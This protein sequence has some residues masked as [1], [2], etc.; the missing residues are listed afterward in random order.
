MSRILI[1]GVAGFIGRH[2]FERL[3]TYNS[4][5]WVGLDLKDKVTGLP[6]EIRLNHALY[7]CD[8]R[9]S[10]ATN[11][12]AEDMVTLKVD[13]V[14]HLAAMAA[15]RIAESQPEVTWATNV[16]GTYNLLNAMH[17]AKVRKLVFMS[18]AH[19]YGISPKYMPTDESHPLALLDLYT[20]SKVMGEQLCELFYQN[21]GIDYVALRLYNGYGPGQSPDYFMGTKIR[22]AAKGDFELRGG[23][24]TKDWVYIDDVVDAIWRA[25][26]TAYVGPLNIGTGEE[27]SLRD[28]ATQ[29]AQHFG[30]K[31]HEVV[32]G[33]GGPTRMCADN[34]RARRILDWDPEVKF[35]K[36]LRKTLESFR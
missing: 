32:D 36:G 31:F 22:E 3:N 27:T 8:L 1:T 25:S 24:V 16:Q 5:D 34:S 12:L 4:V 23:D 29:I 14:I 20:T 10:A 6:E 9:D 35:G 19:V 21:H 11:K 30:V 2:L 17:K 18:S 28:I 26:L 7:R 13:R 33:H 15:P